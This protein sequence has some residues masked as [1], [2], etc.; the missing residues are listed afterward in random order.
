MLDSRDVS[1]LKQEDSEGYND[2]YKMLEEM[3]GLI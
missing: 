2:V 3:A 1:P